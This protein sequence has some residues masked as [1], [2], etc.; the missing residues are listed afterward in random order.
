MYKHK[1]NKTIVHIFVRILFLFIFLNI[2]IGYNHAQTIIPK[3]SLI[4]VTIGATKSSGSNHLL[5]DKK[6]VNILNTETMQISIIPIANKTNINSI[7][8]ISIDN[9]L[10]NA[11]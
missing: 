7:N 10:N 4:V 3:V 2:Y 11:I 6:A 5:N 1:E 8:P 9:L